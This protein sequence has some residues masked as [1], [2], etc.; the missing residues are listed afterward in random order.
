MLEVTLLNVNGEKEETTMFREHRKINVKLLYNLAAFYVNDK[1]KRN[2]SGFTWNIFTRRHYSRNLSEKI[3]IS[4]N[5]YSLR[6]ATN[7]SV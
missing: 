5:T 1:P 6:V 7:L 4:E 3:C 2:T